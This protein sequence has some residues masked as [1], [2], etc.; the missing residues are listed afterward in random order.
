MFSTGLLRALDP[1]PWWEC[2][3]LG[4]GAGSIA[5]WLAERCPD[6]RVVAVDVD[7]RHLDAGGARNLEVA[8]Q[9]VTE[10]GYEPGLFDLVHA[11]YLFSHLPARDKVLARA[12]GWLK[13]GGWLVLEEP[14]QLPAD[15]SPFP[16][17]RRIMEAYRNKYAE[18]GADLTWARSIPSALAASGLTEVDFTG[19]LACMG[20]LQRDRWRPLIAQVSPAL[21]EE[22]SISRADLDE[23]THLLDDPAFVDV[24]QFTLAAWARRAY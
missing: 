12:A 24:P 3:E 4:A 7:T 14:Y 18:H 17:V 15:T 5:Y 11:R 10:D 6:G 21:L 20:N 8:E 13:P 22:G 19:R 1:L 2:L 23:F 9:D 16:V